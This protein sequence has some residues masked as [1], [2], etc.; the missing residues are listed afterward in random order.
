MW[1]G[2]V[3]GMIGAYDYQAKEHFRDTLLN[4]STEYL[5]MAVFA[6]FLVSKRRLCRI[7]SGLRQ[8]LSECVVPKMSMG[9][10]IRAR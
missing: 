10:Q 1:I 8:T 9:T 2:K 7:V 3:S 4:A 6:G 5:I